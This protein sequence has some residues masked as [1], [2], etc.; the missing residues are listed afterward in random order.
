MLKRVARDPVGQAMVFDTMVKLFLEHVLGVSSTC[1][2][3][4][5]S[6]GFA[7]NGRGGLFGPAQA[8]FG[9]VETQGRGGLHVHMQVWISNPMKGVFLEKLRKGDPIHD[10]EGRMRAWREAVLE[11]VAS[12]QFDSVEE[13][14][15]QL[16][17]PGD[18]E[19][20]QRVARENWACTEREAYQP[21]GSVPGG[22]PDVSQWQLPPVPF[23]K[24]MRSQA[25]MTGWLEADDRVMLPAHPGAP[26]D[27]D[28]VRAVPDGPCA[29][30]C[31]SRPG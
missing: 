28:W 11:K 3:S 4:K 2:S 12:M 6:D 17:L 8:Y 21:G 31:A 30:R 16:D 23:T 15:R 9:P 24:K 5:F 13:F 10:L 25:Y 14:G 7:A 1:G 20:P 26:A 29:R 27:A 22:E 19:G 18:P